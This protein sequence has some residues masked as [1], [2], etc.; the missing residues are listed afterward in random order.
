MD[1][2]VLADELTTDPLVRGYAG[3]TDA[4]AADDLNT[5][6]R[7]SPAV[8]DDIL[9]YIVKR[10]HRTQQGTDTTFTAIVGRL[11]HA[12]G[13]AVGDDPF[14]RGAGN[15]LT[16]VHLHACKFFTSLI[17]SPQISQLDFSDVNLPTGQVNGSGV[18]SSA[19]ASDIEALSDNQ[20]SRAIELGLGSVTVG[21]VEYAR[22]L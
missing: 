11:F 21:D 12:S 19:H 3:M 9:Q 1:Y 4:Q 13:S 14:G 18:W 15:E 16:L 5:V 7:S 10:N 20:I 8:I 17:N 6:Y 22:A 2:P